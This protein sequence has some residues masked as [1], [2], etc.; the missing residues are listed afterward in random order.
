MQ[1]CR[2]ARAQFTSGSTVEYDCELNDD[3]VEAVDA[4]EGEVGG[5]AGLLH[6]EKFPSKSNIVISAAGK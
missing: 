2:T 3:V 1:S 4:A 5:N 6:L